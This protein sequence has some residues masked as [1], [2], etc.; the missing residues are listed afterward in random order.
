MDYMP[1]ES[2]HAMG[3]LVAAGVVV[4]LAAVGAA[5][6]FHLALIHGAVGG[7]IV[8]FTLA[9]LSKELR[10]AFFSVLAGFVVLGLLGGGVWFVVQTF[11][12]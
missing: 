10:H 3:K 7:G 12:K 4:V 6:G 11:A 9:M 8:G 5:A 1:T 2:E